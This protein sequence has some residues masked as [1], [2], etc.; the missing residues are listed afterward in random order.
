MASLSDSQAAGPIRQLWGGALTASIPQSYLDVSTIRE[1][2]DAQEVFLER[3][4]LVSISLD[5]LSRE[6]VDAQTDEVVANGH[7][8]GDFSTAT[9]VLETRNRLAVRA[10]VE[11]ICP[12]GSMTSQIESVEVPGFEYVSNF[13]NLRQI[14]RLHLILRHASCTNL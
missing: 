11:D 8:D 2:P 13:H 4:G 10:H 3:D 6:Q 7:V 14:H 5:L 9:D 12:Q 1:V